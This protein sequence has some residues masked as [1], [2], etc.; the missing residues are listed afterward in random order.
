V[1]IAPTFSVPKP[2]GWTAD[3]DRRW[4]QIFARILLT[5]GHHSKD[6][7][8]RGGETQWGCSLRFL[9]AVG[10]IDA[11]HDGFADL[12]LNFDTV[13]DGHD[14][15]ALTPD[16]AGELYLKHFM[17]APGIWSLPRPF[18]AALFDQAVNGGTTAAIK[19][20]Q[21]ALN[22]Q[23]GPSLKVDGDLGP[24]TRAQLTESLGRGRP[25]LAALRTEAAQRYEAIVA[26]DPSQKKYLKGWLRR[27]Q[28]LG[29]V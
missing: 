9:K 25:V 10:C 27:A 20:L 24:R 7:S 21:R 6:P 29:R 15:R 13:I 22:R 17:I 28:E 11:N 19:L 16:I 8:D 4:R 26:A 3:N 23:D 2:A 12:D 5:E 14:V 18:D 1:N